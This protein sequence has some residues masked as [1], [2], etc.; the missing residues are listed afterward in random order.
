MSV[1]VFIGGL[2]KTVLL[3][4]LAI[5]NKENTDKFNDCLN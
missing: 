2:F 1:S 3:V 5:H 4:R